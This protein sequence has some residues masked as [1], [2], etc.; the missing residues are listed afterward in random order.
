MIALLLAGYDINYRLSSVFA[1]GR[2]STYVLR[3]YAP[4]ESLTPTYINECFDSN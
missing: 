1:D 2:Y 3:V 4:T